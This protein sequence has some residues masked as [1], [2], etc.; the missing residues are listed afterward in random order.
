[1]ACTPLAPLS[2]PSQVR[3]YLMADGGNVELVEVDGPVVYLR[4]QGACGS[5]PSSLTTMTMGIKRRLQERIPVSGWGWEWRGGVAG[6][7]EQRRWHT[8]A[9]CPPPSLTPLLLLHR[10]ASQEI[11]EVEQI[12]DENKGLELTATNIETVL[13]EIRCV[14]AW[15]GVGGGGGSGARLPRDCGRP[16]T[17]N[18]PSHPTHPPL[19]RQALP[20]GHRWGGA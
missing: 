14:W 8:R 3:P 1:M 18:P 5:C 12:M 11:L 9:E 19:L 10:A 6:Q 13:D 7:Q 16:F 15:A 2:L 17:L 4:L 20:G